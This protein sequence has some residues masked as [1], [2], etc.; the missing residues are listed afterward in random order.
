[1][2]RLVLYGKAD[3]HLCEEMKAVVAEVQ[4]EIPFTLET[5]DIDSDARLRAA[6]GAEIPVLEIDGR[7]AFKYRVDAV[8]LRRRLRR[9]GGDAS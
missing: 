4:A 8:A 1:M 6:Y 7:K 9:A 3:C 5:I 2:T